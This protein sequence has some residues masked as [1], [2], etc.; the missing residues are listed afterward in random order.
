MA[1]SA[2]KLRRVA[3]L[4]GSRSNRNGAANASKPPPKPPALTNAQANPASTRLRSWRIISVK[5]VRN[6]LMPAPSEFPRHPRIQDD[7]LPHNQGHAPKRR[8]EPI[9]K[10]Q[11]P[12]PYDD[13]SKRQLQDPDRNEGPE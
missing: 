2:S 7:F 4:L 12:W 9:P 8:N 5:N 13:H 3:E 1:P 10:T 11:K 6:G